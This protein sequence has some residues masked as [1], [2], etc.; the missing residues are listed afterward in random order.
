MTMLSPWIVQDSHNYHAHN[1]QMYCSVHIPGTPFLSSRPG[2][3]DD[4]P[5]AVVLGGNRHLSGGVSLSEEID[6][7]GQRS[8]AAISEYS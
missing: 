4:A 1:Q 3:K 7:R 8:S 2:S 6:L 5:K